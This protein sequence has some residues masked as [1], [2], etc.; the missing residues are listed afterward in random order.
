M[1]STTQ[2]ALCVCMLQSIPGE[3]HMHPKTGCMA[4]C[5]HGLVSMAVSS[6]QCHLGN[7]IMAR[8]AWHCQQLHG[9][10]CRCLATT[11]HSTLIA[12]GSEAGVVRLVD[13][14][15]IGL[16]VVHRSKLHQGPIRRMAFSP[17]GK[18][19]AVLA[20]TRSA[21]ETLLCHMSS[22]ACAACIMMTHDAVNPARVVSIHATAGVGSTRPPVDCAQ[23]CWIALVYHAQTQNRLMLSLAPRMLSLTPG[24]LSFTPRMLSLPPIME[25]NE[26]STP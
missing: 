19:L 21:A 4:Q 20:G 2:L 16:T 1:Q 5:H 12:L 24:M 7:V 14:A 6:W 8:L 10:Q 26:K 9:V 22:T 11:M 23:C 13:S 17:D 25:R 15:A 18:T 3:A